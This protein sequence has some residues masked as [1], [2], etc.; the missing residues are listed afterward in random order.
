MRN[1]WS[2]LALQEAFFEALH[3]GRHSCSIHVKEKNLY[4]KIYFGFLL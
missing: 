4:Q 1:T 2:P 3:A